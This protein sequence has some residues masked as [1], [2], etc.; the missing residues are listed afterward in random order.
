VQKAARTII[1]LNWETFTTPPL[2][3][4]VRVLDKNE[5]G[6]PAFAIRAVRVID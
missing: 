6:M 1:A 3:T 2:W 4:W 5:P